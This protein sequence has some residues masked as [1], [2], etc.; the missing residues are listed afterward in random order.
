[1]VVKIT[2]WKEDKPE[3]HLKIQFA[4]RS[5][6]SVSAIKS[7]QLMLDTEKNRSLF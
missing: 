1:M 6:H 5:V 7:N 4:L 3:L 2:F